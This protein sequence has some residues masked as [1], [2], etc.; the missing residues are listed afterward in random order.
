[1]KKVL[2]VAAH[3]DDE[4]LGCGGTVARHVDEGDVVQILFMADGVTSR[5]LFNKHDLRKRNKAAY[6][7]CEILGTES[8][9]FLGFPDNKMDTVALLDI[10]KKLEKV[11]DKTQP[12]VIYT[13]HDQDL[14]IDH[15]I[16]HQ[17]VIT[18]CRPQ[19][20]SYI[21]EIYSFEILSS[22]EWNSPS[23][24]N[25]FIPNRFVDISKSI[26]RKIKALNAYQ[27]EMREFPHSR[28]IETIK[29]L[30]KY[31]GSTV[32]MRAAESFKME[33]VLLR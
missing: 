9:L 14:N 18:A 33:R 16:T 26:E 5:R 11:I 28:S 17:A 21:N 31:R 29:L 22:T 13:H 27:E 25:T 3:P 23:A 19:P 20:K 7:S 2:V 24:K 15:R 8:P 12:S 32:G 1:M 10:V 4:V 6:E 30:A